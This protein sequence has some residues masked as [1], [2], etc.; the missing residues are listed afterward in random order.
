[1][2]ILCHNSNAHVNKIDLITT[3]TISEGLKKVE[4]LEWRNKSFAEM[5]SLILENVV[6]RKRR[7]YRITEA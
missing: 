7:K 5:L 1:M 4:D 6:E 3:V 2:V